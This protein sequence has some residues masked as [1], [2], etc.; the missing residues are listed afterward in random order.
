MC[1]LEPD[2]ECD[3]LETPTLEVPCTM[4]FECDSELARRTNRQRKSG[5]CGLIDEA[6]RFHHDGQRR[7]VST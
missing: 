7:Y 1:E 4:I 2:C 6:E 3:P 5:C